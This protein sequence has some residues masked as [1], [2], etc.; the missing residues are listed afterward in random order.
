M[1]KELRTFV[2]EIRKDRAIWKD[3]E[4]WTA[5]LAAASSAVLLRNRP[6]LIPQMRAHFPDLLTTLSIVFGFALTTTALYVGSVATW[7]SNENSAWRQ[8]ARVRRAAE[9]LVN[10]NVWAML[11]I[12]AT[13]TWTIFLWTVD[14]Y[15]AGDHSWPRILLYSFLVFSAFYAGGQIVNQVL[16]LTWFHKKLERFAGPG[17]KAE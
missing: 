3:G 6:D 13:L 14:E 2:G 9:R 17:S 8:D 12:V 11:W 1:F 16:T 5:M 10:W 15:P 4:L 7:S